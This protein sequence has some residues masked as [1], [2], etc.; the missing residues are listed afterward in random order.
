M[1]EILM[2]MED[3]AIHH[4]VPIITKE[5]IAFIMKYIKN[6]KVKEVLELGSAIGYSAILMASAFADTKV[7]TIEK[8][9]NRYL[10]C[11]NNVK[12]CQLENKINVVYQDA[13][14]LNLI[15]VSYDLIFIDAAKADYISLF[16]KYKYFL[17]PGGVIITDNINFHG[18]VG[19]TKNIQ[20]ENLK[21]IVTKIEEYIEFLKSNKD[22][23]TT[24]YDVGDGLSITT[25]K[26]SS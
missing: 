15:G 16:E 24:F 23:E 25:K 14:D 21:K 6:N 13:L 4:N 5:G 3:Y 18:Y 20:D 9:E 10:E 17:K 19:N 7:T 2:A 11:L 12:K 26:V 8:N 22:Y 1:K